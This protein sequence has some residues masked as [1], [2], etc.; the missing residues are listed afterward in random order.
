[1]SICGNHSSPLQT[2]W[3]I[4]AMCPWCY[5]QT[6]C[7]PTPCWRYLCSWS[8]RGSKLLSLTHDLLAS[9]DKDIQRNRHKPAHPCLILFPGATV[10]SCVE[11]LS[12]E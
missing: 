4:L 11:G 5:L 3:A 6:C 7:I 10:S 9:T 2:T 1:M 8:S 12:V